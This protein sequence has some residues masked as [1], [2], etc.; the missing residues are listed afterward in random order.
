MTREKLDALVELHKKWLNNDLSGKRLV[1]KDVNLSFV[2]LCNTDLRGAD[3][4]GAV[5]QL[6]SFLSPM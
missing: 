2:N 3:L 1:L 5:F 6:N 4:R